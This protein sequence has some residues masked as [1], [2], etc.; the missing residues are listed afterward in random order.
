M[1]PLDRSMVVLPDGD[2]LMRLALGSATETALEVQ[3]DALGKLLDSARCSA[4]MDHC[5]A[6][7]RVT[8]ST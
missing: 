1:V 5:R 2:R 8:T 7:V 3:S 4:G 6:A